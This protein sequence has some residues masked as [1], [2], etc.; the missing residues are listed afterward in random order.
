MAVGE[1]PASLRK[2][3]QTPF[4]KHDGPEVEIAAAG[5]FRVADIYV[6][7]SQEKK[8]EAYGRAPEGA[9]CVDQDPS[10]RTSASRL[11]VPAGPDIHLQSQARRA[12]TED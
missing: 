11:V 4:F 3:P 8:H 12:V 2:L 9:H 5:N 7:Q 6:S 1:F 10:L